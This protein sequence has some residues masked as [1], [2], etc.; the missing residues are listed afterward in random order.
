MSGEPLESKRIAGKLLVF[1]QGRGAPI[2][3]TKRGQ[4]RHRD[5]NSRT[6]MPP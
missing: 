2:H 1:D 3:R 4:V 6:Q 5:A